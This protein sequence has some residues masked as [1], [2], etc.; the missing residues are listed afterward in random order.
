MEHHTYFF[1]ILLCTVICVRLW[2]L[3]NPISSPHFLNF[4]FHHY[5]YGLVIV[6]ISLLFS[7]LI[8][9]GVGVGLIVDELPLFLRYKNNHFHWKEYNSLY[10]RIGVIICLILLFIFRNYIPLI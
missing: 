4:K 3:L 8:M 10:S 9:Y 2:L 5:M 6:G 1:I 7:N